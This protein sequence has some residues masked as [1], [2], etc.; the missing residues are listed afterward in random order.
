MFNYLLKKTRESEK[1]PFFDIFFDF[2]KVGLACES[3]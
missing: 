2:W 3:Q 1:I